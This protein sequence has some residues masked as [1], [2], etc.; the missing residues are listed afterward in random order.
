MLVLSSGV[1]AQDGAKSTQPAPIEVGGAIAAPQK[2]QHVQPVYPVLAKQS[3]V[4]GAVSLSIVINPNGIV[5][6][7]TVVRSIPALNDAAI[8]AVKQ[9]KY[10]P[11]LVDGVA[12]PVTMVVHVN[13]S[14]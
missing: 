4:Q 8:A 5:E 9:W 11:T 6:R 1:Q 3:R 13:F 7:A 12:V 10:A 14:L 2:R